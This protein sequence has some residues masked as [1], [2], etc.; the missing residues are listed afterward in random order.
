MVR[1]LEE[2]SARDGC[3]ADARSGFRQIGRVE[4]AHLGGLGEALAEAGR[5]E[6]AVEPCF[7]QAFALDGN[8]DRRLRICHHGGHV[9]H[10]AG[11]HRDLVRVLHADGKHLSS[12]PGIFPVD[13]DF[14]QVGLG[15][16][17]FFVFGVGRIFV[18]EIRVVAFDVEAELQRAGG[19]ARRGVVIDKAGAADP[20]GFPIAA[21]ERR[22]M[23]VRDLPGSDLLH[24]GE[25]EIIHSVENGETFITLKV[26][27]T[28]G[29]DYKLY[30]TPKYVDTKAGFEA[31]KAQSARVGDIKAFE[32][33]RLQVPSPVNV[34]DHPAA[35]VGCEKLSMF[36][37]SAQLK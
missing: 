3:V 4:V 18:C 34:N 14:N 17:V 5:R 9:L 32:N 8:V 7:A 15:P 19:V 36:I 25:G 1:A 35:L 31:V 13:G 28:P 6:A 26:Y 24:Y 37:S 23:F 20:G 16:G 33:F 11:R 12:Q 27:V 29:P 21:A 2:T 10:E 22:G 30:L